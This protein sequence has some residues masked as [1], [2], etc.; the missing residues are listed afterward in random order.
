MTSGLTLIACLLLSAGA[1]AAQSTEASEAAAQQA[2]DAWLKVID[3]G[4][5]GKAWDQSSTTFRTVVPRRDFE[6]KMKAARGPLGKFLFR[7]VSG[8]K[9]THSI[10]GAPGGTYVIVEYSAQFQ[11]REHAVETV[12]MML[13][14]GGKFRGAGYDVR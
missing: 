2:A 8:K 12:T 13:D 4:N 1:P 6:K 5:L 3:T 10:P 11:K 7:K 9:L 14:T